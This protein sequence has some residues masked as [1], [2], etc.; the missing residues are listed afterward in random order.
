MHVFHD[1]MVFFPRKILWV[2]MHDHIRKIGKV[3]QK[4]VPCFQ[5]NHMG[6]GH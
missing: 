2:N 4:L 6:F 5:G 3:M 1:A